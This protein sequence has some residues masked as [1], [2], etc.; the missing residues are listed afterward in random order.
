MGSGPHSLLMSFANSS[1]SCGPMP[2]SLLAHSTLK[3]LVLLANRESQI[4]SLS[5]KMPAPRAGR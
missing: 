2:S 1:L 5:Q 4:K 3:L